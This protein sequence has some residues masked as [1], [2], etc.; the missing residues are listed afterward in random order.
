MRRL[1]VLDLPG[2]SPRIMTDPENYPNI[3]KL[4]DSGHKYS[5]TPSFPALTASMQATITTGQ[6]A[7]RHGM[8]A[9]GLYDRRRYAVDLWAQSHK[10]VEGERIW[11]TLR[12]SMPD[13]KTG[14][15]CFQNIMFSGCD[16]LLT[17]AP[18][19][20]H[21]GKLISSCYTK[22]IGLYDELAAEIGE[23]NLMQYW[24][25]M[26][27]IGSSQWIAKAAA[28]I[29][30]K[31]E[32]NLLFVYLPHLDYC[33]QKFGPDAPQ[34]QPELKA[35][36]E[37]VGGLVAEAGAENVA[38]ISEYGMTPVSGAVGINRLLRKGGYISVREVGGME[39][40][41]MGMSRAF[42][43]VDHQ[44]AHVFFND[45]SAVSE[46]RS[47]LEETEGV[48][49]VLGETGKKELCIDHPNAG[50]LVA[51]SDPDKWF[52]Y[53]WWLDPKKA[54]DF[55]YTVDIHN[56]P[57]YDPQELFF[58]PVNKCIAQDS[59]LVKGS[60]GLVAEDVRDLPMF[61]SQREAGPSENG[62]IDATDVKSAIIDLLK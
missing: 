17:P 49:R 60:H 28:K 52:S 50:E 30:N 38:V 42:A 34:I 25:P 22:P 19:H 31:F 36:D 41:D 32:L 7:A 20:L 56:K 53:Q 48:G 24:G 29:W 21:D 8:I 10:L 18:K 62:K 61:V 33:L 59:S 9:N 35:L 13:A 45:P 44:V 57:G 14:V 27:G 3:K 47:L 55:A 54:P 6:S 2:L 23:F 11:D 39:Y 43:M 15:I 46:V 4:I 40:L 1:M 12:D 51:L 16:V 5:V 58:D 26:A 37:L